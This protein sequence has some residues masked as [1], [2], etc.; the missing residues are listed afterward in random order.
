VVDQLQ[1]RVGTPINPVS[2]YEPAQNVLRYG[3]F[4]SNAT[5]PQSFHTRLARNLQSNDHI[6]L[7]RRPLVAIGQDWN[8]DIDIVTNFAI[9]Y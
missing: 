9:C 5:S 2:L 7:L 8:A 4:V 6:R 1:L 3:Q